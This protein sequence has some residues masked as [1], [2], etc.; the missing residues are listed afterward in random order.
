MTSDDSP[1]TVA[2]DSVGQQ[3]KQARERHG[4]SISQIANAQ[5]LRNG[6]IQAIE[7]GD[8]GQIDS[9][10]FLKGYVRAYAKQVGL[11][12]D[13][14]IADLNRELEPG[15][16]QKARELEANPLIDIERRRRRKRRIAK[17]FL[18]VLAVVLLAA[19]AVTLIMPKLSSDAADTELSGAAETVGQAGELTAPGSSDMRADESRDAPATATEPDVTPESRET[20]EGEPEQVG[21]GPENIATEPA[22]VSEEFTAD[23]IPVVAQTP[24]PALSG[25]AADDDG[26]VT[27]KLEIVFTGDCWVQV[28]DANGDR[29]ASSLQRA[30]DRL[31]VSGKAPLKVVI[32]AVDTVDTIRFQGEP[33]D[34]RN[35]PVVNNRSEFTLTI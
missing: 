26:L 4:L 33:V 12:G 22:E 10:L 31:E 16:L 3:L 35:F 15:R 32:G 30:G 27:G 25:P 8:Y 17:L 24:E 23:Q 13:A 18:L 9:E 14:I 29:L 21:A 2:H 1:Q 5:H 19:L 20:A 6:I 7:N 34:I 11:D 28:R